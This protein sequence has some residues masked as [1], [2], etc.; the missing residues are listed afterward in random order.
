M[1]IDYLN[2]KGEAFYQLSL[3]EQDKNQRV[4]YL[5][6]CYKNL[7][8]SIEQMY[9]YKLQLPFEEQIYLYSG[10]TRKSYPN[11]IKVCLELY[12][13]TGEIRFQEKAFQFAEQA[14]AT[15]M[16]SMFRGNNAGKIGLLPAPYKALEDSVNLQATVIHQRLQAMKEDHPEMYPLH[17][18]LDM[19]AAKR[20]E[21]ERMYRNRYPLYYRL[22]YST[23]VTSVP[24][25]Q[26]YLGNDE[27]LVEFLLH[28][29]FLITF[30]IDKKNFLIKTDSL[31]NI[32]LTR[33][34]ETFY[35]RMSQFSLEHYQPGEVKAF[36]ADAGA[37]Y[38]LLLRP[39]EN[40][41]QEKKIIV[42]ADNDLQKVAFEVL[43]TGSPAD[44]S[45]YRRLPY[46]LRRNTVFYTPSATF[47]GELRKRETTGRRAKLLAVAPEYPGKDNTRSGS[48]RAVRPGTSILESLPYARKEVQF[49]H[50]IAGGRLLSGE[51]ASE[52]RFKKMVAG[53]EIIHLAAHGRI[54]E[55]SMFDSGLV[56]AGDT[57]PDDGFLYNYEIYGLKHTSRLVILSACNTGNGKNYEGEGMISTGRSFLSSGSRSVIMTLWKINDLASYELMKGFYIHLKNK[58]TISEALRKSKLDF[59]R[60][61]DNL[62]SHP[63]FWSAYI[64]YGDASF[65]VKIGSG[66]KAFLWVIP[67]LFVLFTAFFSASRKLFPYKRSGS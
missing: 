4:K 3:L 37:L 50:A 11:M 1:L 30:Y 23:E 12:N 43:L 67:G 38:N 62:H 17:A 31:K 15:V 53:Y 33:L 57:L 2:N 8:L 29:N 26:Q 22:R 34:T 52:T 13:Q 16:L 39:F 46:L 5:H 42:V 65:S 7:N 56:F 25:I 40:N 19:L 64:G 36:A 28:R 14:R 55:E 63:F 35:H 51:E 54:N 6:E 61:T 18:K 21:L 47:L 24:A 27:C 60:Q 41:I 48:I 20:A 10:L 32:N 44:L 9:K 59:L 66:G 58:F 45:G 49:A